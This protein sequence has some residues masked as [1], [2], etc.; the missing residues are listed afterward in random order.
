MNGLKR[1]AL[2]MASFLF[3]ITNLK[4]GDDSLKVEIT[5]VNNFEGNVVIALY[6]QEGNFPHRPFKKFDVDKGALKN[7]RLEYL[8]PQIL[9]G[10]YAIAL[11]DDKNE[12]RKM[13]KTWLGLPKEGYGFSNNAKPSLTGAPSFEKCT[14]SIGEDEVVLK[15]EMQYF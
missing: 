14:F 15:I 1:T 10:V 3:L 4:A 7:G 6:Q 13:D 9:P 12:N 8:I 2:I 11:L 5:N